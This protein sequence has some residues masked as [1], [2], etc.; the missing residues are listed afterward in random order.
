MSRKQ[1]VIYGVTGSGKTTLA[2]RLARELGLRHVELDSLYHGPGWTPTPPEEFRAKVQKELDASPAGW[3]ADGNYTAVRGFLLPQADTVVWLRLPWRVSYSR[4]LR[5]TFSR[6]I[7]R[8]ELWNGNKESLRLMFF[9]KESLLLWG[10][11]QH[12]PSQERIGGA[13]DEIPHAAEVFE[14]HSAREVEALVLR[15]VAERALV[16]G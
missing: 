12:R 16:E 6:A 10:I 8:K 4:M 1:I 15:F 9:D 7:T 5:R 13:L 2:R 14:P 3:V 11:R